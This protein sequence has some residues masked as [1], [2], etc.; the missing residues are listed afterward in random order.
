MLPFEIEKIIY[1]YHKD[2]ECL[3]YKKI[4]EEIQSYEKERRNKKDRRFFCDECNNWIQYSHLLR[5]NACIS[6]KYKNH[7]IIDD[8]YKF[9]Y[10]THK[11]NIESL[12]NHRR[13]HTEWNNT[14]CDWS[15]DCDGEY[16]TEWNNTKCDW[17]EDCDSEYED[18]GGDVWRIGE[19]LCIQC[20]KWNINMH[21]TP[22]QGLPPIETKYRE[23]TGKGWGCLTC[24]WFEDKYKPAIYVLG[25]DYIVNEYLEICNKFDDEIDD[26]YT[27]DFWASS[28]DPWF[29]D[30][31]YPK[32][33]DLNFEQKIIYDLYNLKINGWINSNLP[34]IT[35]EQDNDG[36]CNYCNEKYLGDY[37]DCDE[38]FE[39]IQSR[40]ILK[41]LELDIL[42]EESESE[43]EEFELEQ[44]NYKQMKVVELKK[45]CKTR[46]IK[47]Y[48]KLRKKQ[49]IEILKNY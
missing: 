21:R 48:S 15:E 6:C 10:S 4:N 17:S 2:L 1:S 37:C 43:S 24:K 8:K 41:I 9:K 34:L 40:T 28:Y 38:R 46:G 44:I 47:G 25:R 13:F 30:P 14:K 27:I 45:L 49:L 16:H 5:L 3:K 7:Y 20:R 32:L 42:H 31:C 12:I 33:E 19:H 35:C 22:D 18:M 11:Q 39:K 36:F 29:F 26:K 23:R